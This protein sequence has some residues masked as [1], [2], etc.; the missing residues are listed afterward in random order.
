MPAQPAELSRRP[1]RC[2][3]LVADRV[4]HSLE[5]QRGGGIG[6]RPRDVVRLTCLQLP[7]LEG[8]QVLIIA[9]VTATPLGWGAGRI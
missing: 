4:L 2:W 7:M 6:E 5:W 3:L 9:G 1:H 8:R